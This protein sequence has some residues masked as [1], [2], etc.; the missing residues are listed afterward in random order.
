MKNYD[1]YELLLSKGA[2]PD[3][4]DNLGNTA[5]NYLEMETADEADGIIDQPIATQSISEEEILIVKDMEWIINYEARMMASA[6]LERWHECLGKEKYHL[7]EEGLGQ[8]LREVAKDRPVDPI[9]TLAKCL[10]KFHR[11]NCCYCGLPPDVCGRDVNPAQHLRGHRSKMKW[12]ELRRL[13]MAKSDSEI[14]LG[15]SNGQNSVT[16]N[17]SNSDFGSMISG[18][19]LEGEID[20]KLLDLEKTY[21]KM[22]KTSRI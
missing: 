12:R 1:L 8:C 14:K 19:N 4:E 17:L 18:L 13:V 10:R 21:K 5:A 6:K 9:G 16:E 11:Q 3:T 20:E 22:S 7:L 2:N 15:E